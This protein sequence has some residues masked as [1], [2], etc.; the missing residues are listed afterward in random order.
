MI[1]YLF[2]FLLLILIFSCQKAETTNNVA[3]L[4]SVVGQISGTYHTTQICTS[5]SGSDTSYNI[6]VSVA[7]LNDTTLVIMGQQLSFTGNLSTKSYAFSCCLSGTA[8][9]SFSVD[10]NFQNFSY[11]NKVGNITCSYKSRFGKGWEIHSALGGDSS[12][13]WIA[14]RIYPSIWPRRGYTS[15]AY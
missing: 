11:T 4:R 1:R 10:S 3:Q 15:M 14:D 8:S 12:K 13:W 5:G 2:T 6:S 7:N 9:Y